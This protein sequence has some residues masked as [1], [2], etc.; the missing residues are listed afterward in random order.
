MDDILSYT[1]AFYSTL[2]NFYIDRLLIYKNDPSKPGHNYTVG[3]VWVVVPPQ[4]AE[5]G[6]LEREA[7]TSRI[8]LALPTIPPA[9]SGPHSPNSWHIQTPEM[10]QYVTLITHNRKEVWW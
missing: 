6:I 3:L 10:A 2:C 7:V 1:L 4:R 5:W 9:H 8:P